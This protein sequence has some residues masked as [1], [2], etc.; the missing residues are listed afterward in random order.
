MTDRS[1]A[2][3]AIT[4]HGPGALDA[5]ALALEQHGAD[6]SQVRALEA[7]RHRAVALAGDRVLAYTAGWLGVRGVRLL[8]T[9]QTIAGLA[10]AL[11]SA[12]VPAIE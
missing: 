8:A 10:N 6:A 2:T 11:A 9:E 1:S 5:A 12:G 3:H 7:L 4:V